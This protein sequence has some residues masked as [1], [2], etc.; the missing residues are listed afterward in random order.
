[1]SITKAQIKKLEARLGE[2]GGENQ[3]K[4]KIVLLSPDGM[5]Y[6]IA[7]IKNGEIIGRIDPT[8]VR[9]AALMRRGVV[10]LPKFNLDI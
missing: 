4:Y 7:A 1:M 10:E 3:I 8:S 6:E 5:H 9:G 2:L